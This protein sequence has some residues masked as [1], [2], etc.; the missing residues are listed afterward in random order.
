MAVPNEEPFKSPW[1]GGTGPGPSTEKESV[2]GMS[3]SLGGGAYSP[4]RPTLVSQL[5]AGSGFGG[6]ANYTPLP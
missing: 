3:G 4:P 6:G 5:P 1:L 2:S